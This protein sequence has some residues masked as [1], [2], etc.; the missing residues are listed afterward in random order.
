[1]IGEYSQN[2]TFSIIVS[3]DKNK[4]NWISTGHTGTDAKCTIHQNDASPFEFIPNRPTNEFVTVTDR[5]RP[6]PPL[7]ASLDLLISLAI[8]PLNE[9]AAALHCTVNWAVKHIRIRPILQSCLHE[10]CQDAFIFS[11]GLMNEIS[12]ATL[13]DK[14]KPAYVMFLRVSHISILYSTRHAN[15]KYIYTNAHNVCANKLCRKTYVTHRKSP[16]S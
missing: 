10:R 15:H 5:Q 6:K 9:C 3:S 11:V 7:D 2:N 8:P 16:I 4:P 1:M 13:L 12:A 14:Q